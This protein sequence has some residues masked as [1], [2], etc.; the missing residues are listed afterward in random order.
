MRIT[1][2]LTAMLTMALTASAE[3]VTFPLK[4]SD[5]RRY[6]VDQHNKPFL[7]HADI[8]RQIYVKLTTAETRDYLIHRKNQRFNTIQTQIAMYPELANRY[9][10]LIF[11]D[12]NDFS[13][14]NEAYHEHVAEI[15]ALAD[16]LNL[17]ISMSQPWLG[18]CQEAFGNRPDKPKVCAKP[19][20]CTSCSLIMPLRRV[21]ARICFSMP[22]SGEYSN[23]EHFAQ[24]EQMT[25]PGNQDW[26]LLLKADDYFFRSMGY[27]C[28]V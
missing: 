22:I 27:R 8:G 13:K 16:S 9:G 18:C 6:F 19:R 21:P 5:N 3:R 15:I 20:P 24:L 25:R 23:A 17:L 10:S 2:F 11:D 14:P 4:I 28:D 12:N 7:Y 1:V 26:V